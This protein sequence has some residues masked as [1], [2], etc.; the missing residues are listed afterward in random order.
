ME[1]LIPKILHFCWLSG[2]PYP[3]EI[4]K[5]LN[6]WKEKLPEYTLMLWDTSKVD[7]NVCNWTKQAYEKKKYAFVSDYVRFYALYNYGGIYLDTDVEVIKSFDDLLNQ[8]FFFS[9]EYTTIPEAAVIGAKKGLP[10]IKTC[11]DWYL[12]N[13]FFDK[14]GKER[15]I[16]APLVLKY[17]FETTL[18]NTLFDTCEVQKL[19]GGTVYP[20]EYF[21]AWNYYTDKK[22]ITEN[23]YS[24]HQ[25]FSSWLNI[26]C[27]VK[28][29]K[30]LHVLVIK[31]LGKKR[32]NKIKY[33]MRNTMWREI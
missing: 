16:V 32:Y 3:K 11:M 12:K 18:K 20:F 30:R 7:V 2:E 25:F 8:E 6:S 10:W 13:D 24:V 14:D 15:H 31:L 26:N 22:I 9:F 1:G 27:K 21:S 5:C 28:L 17:G 33:K 4:Q 29:K 23:T 19:K